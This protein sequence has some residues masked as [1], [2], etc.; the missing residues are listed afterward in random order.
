MKTAGLPAPPRKAH[1]VA[2]GPPSSSC[3][4]V[5]ES[6]AASRLCRHASE[7]SSHLPADGVGAR[8]KYLAGGEHRPWSDREKTVRSLASDG[9][10]SNSAA[11]R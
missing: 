7:P 9:N 3:L 1:G 8:P 11:R 4:W 6:M 5:P 10:G 2:C